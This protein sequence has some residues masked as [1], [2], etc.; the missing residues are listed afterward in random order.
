M[1]RENV[2]KKSRGV[3]PCCR[4]KH[5]LLMVIRRFQGQFKFPAEID[6]PLAEADRKVLENLWS[7][8]SSLTSTL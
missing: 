6:I 4:E 2:E 5:K 7:F 1:V 8:K 3:A